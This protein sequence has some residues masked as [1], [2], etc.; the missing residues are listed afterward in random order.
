M[1][2][3]KIVLVPQSW[4][5]AVLRWVRVDVDDTSSAHE[6]GQRTLAKLKEQ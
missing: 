1:L 6:R 3:N 4:R 2:Y 5:Q